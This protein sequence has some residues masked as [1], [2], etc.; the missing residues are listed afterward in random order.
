MKFLKAE[1]HPPAATSIA[2]LREGD[3][4]LRWISGDASRPPRP[5]TADSA[6]ARPGTPGRQPR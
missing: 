3:S 6:L 4:N 1:A 2:A 5:L